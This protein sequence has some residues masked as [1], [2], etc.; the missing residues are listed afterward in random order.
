M[1]A[2]FATMAFLYTNIQYC[3]MVRMS[4]RCNDNVNLAVR[5]FREEFGVS[6]WYLPNQHVIIT[7]GKKLF[8]LEMWVT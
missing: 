2:N 8:N 1:R 6:V 7:V 3:E 5:R 4:A